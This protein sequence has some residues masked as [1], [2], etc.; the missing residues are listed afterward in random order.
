MRLLMLTT[1]LVV[2]PLQAL[3]IDRY[4]STGMT[5]NEIKAVIKRDGAA[6]MQYES[7]GSSGILRYDRYVAGRQFCQSAEVV[8]SVYVPSATGAC[9]VLRCDDD[10]LEP[11][12]R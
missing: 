7:Q 3:A 8:R 12:R 5:C 9:P 4:R 1:L 6:I 2:F 11:V 10:D